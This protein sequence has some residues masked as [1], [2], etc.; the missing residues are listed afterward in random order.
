V[1]SQ[2]IN[3]CGT[4]VSQSAGT[5][6]AGSKVV[7]INA[8]TGP[9]LFTL[10]FR[11]TKTFGFGPLRNAPPSQGR[12]GG[13]GGPGGGGPGGGRGGGGGG[14]RGGGGGGGG[15]FGFGG[16]GGGSTG[17]RYN[18]AIG[19]SVNNLFNNTDLAT[20]SGTLTSPN[21]GK[22]TQVEGGPYTSDS[23]IRRIQVQASFN[24]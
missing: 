20:P 15:P 19:L 11:L 16:G 13:Q 21:F 6:P 5:A 9:G 22:S 4:F 10:N 8:C 12:G 7:P 24:F 17:K 1:G 14:G 2:T 3:G 18:L 23:A